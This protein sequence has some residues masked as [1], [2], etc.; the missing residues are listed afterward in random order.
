M[1]QSFEV[2]I[3][4]TR[5]FHETKI[6]KKVQEHNDALERVSK[7]L[8]IKEKELGLAK[9]KGLARERELMNDIEDLHNDMELQ[10]KMNTSAIQELTSDFEAK[11]KKKFG[12]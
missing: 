7:A 1:I 6:A 4:E 5:T 11:I 8:A 12:T 10:K 3:E 9:E 2:K